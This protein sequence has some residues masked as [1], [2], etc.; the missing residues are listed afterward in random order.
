MI[1]APKPMLVSS[2][3]LLPESDRHAFEIKWDGFRAP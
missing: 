3:R 2:G 1:A